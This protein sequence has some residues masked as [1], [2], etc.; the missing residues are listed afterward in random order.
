MQIPFCYHNNI[1]NL[2]PKVPIPKGMACLKENGRL[3]NATNITN[4]RRSYLKYVGVR[5]DAE[6]FEKHRYNLRKESMAERIDRIIET[7]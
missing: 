6:R 2:P 5:N 1:P 4:M 3:H 7:K